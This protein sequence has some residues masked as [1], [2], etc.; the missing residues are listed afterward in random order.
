[1]STYIRANAPNNTTCKTG[2]GAGIVIGGDAGVGAGATGAGANGS[3]GAALFGGDGINAGVFASGGA[4]ANF[5]SHA[6]SAVTS[7]ISPNFFGGG[8]GAG[9]GIILTNASQASQLAGPSATWNVDLGW[10]A[11]GSAQLSQVAD[12]SGNNIYTFS[13][14][15][16]V[17][18]GALYHNVTNVTGVPP[19]LPGWQ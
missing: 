1:M 15:L 9:V 12:A 3:V 8:G 17:G 10:L 2:F 7:I 14:Q 6:A 13:F 18:A 11:N 4:G 16:G 19:A 5:F